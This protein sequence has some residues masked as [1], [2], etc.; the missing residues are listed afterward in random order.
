MTRKFF[1][2]LIILALFTSSAFAQS[3]AE[4]QNGGTNQYKKIRLFSDVYQNSDMNSIRVKDKKG[5][6][7]PYFINSGMLEKEMEKADYPL[8]LINSYQKDENFYF[9]YKLSQEYDSDIISTGLS[10]TTK[11]NNF[12]KQV[13][14]YGSYDNRNW[15]F[16]TG[17]V[18]YK[19]DNNS[20]LD[21]NFSSEEK[22]THIRLELQNNLEKISFETAKLVYNQTKFLESRFINLISPKFEVENVEAEKETYIKISGVS[23]LRIKNIDIISDSTFKRAVRAGNVSDE[24]YNLNFGGQ[25][26]SDRTIEMNGYIEN[27][28]TLTVKIQNKDDEPIDVKMISLGYYVDEVIFEA[29]GDVLLEFGGDLAKPEYD[30]EKYKDEILKQNIDDLKF[31]SMSMG[32]AAPEPEPEKDYTLLFNITIV[33]VALILAV[34]F[35]LKLRKPKE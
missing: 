25:I 3:I 21:I 31:V 7:I 11:S 30:I 18:I 13:S 24:I 22:Y 34:V 2:A 33:A 1:I 12:A 32:E 29:S 28:D 17:D 5:K 15:E 27:E 26:Y 6:N 9:D 20:M 35:V 14:V 23:K 19:I 8:S 4:F 10:F 16:M